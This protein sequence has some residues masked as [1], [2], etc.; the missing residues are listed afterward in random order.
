MRT[1]HRL[2]VIIAVVV[3]SLYT[4]KHVAAA[5]VDIVITRASC[6]AGKV[7]LDFS[8][9]NNSS[10]SVTWSL[11]PLLPLS[12][13]VAPGATQTGTVPTPAS[14]FKGRTIQFPYTRADGTRGRTPVTL[15]IINCSTPTPTT[16][17][18]YL[19]LVSR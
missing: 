4:V 1:V 13:T 17:M 16:H 12:I 2:V 18:V 14:E 8:V 6:A 10:M 11:Q 19:P 7:V 15:P 5:E 9:T 3:S